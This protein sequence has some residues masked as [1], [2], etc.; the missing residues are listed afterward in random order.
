MTFFL[1]ELK[2]S[3]MSRKITDKILK[4]RDKAE[5]LERQAKFIQQQAD[6][7]HVQADE[8][9]KHAKKLSDQALDFLKKAHG[10]EDI[11]DDFSDRYFNLDEQSDRL[12]QQADDLREKAYKLDDKAQNLKFKAMDLRYE[13]ENLKRERDDEIEKKRREK[14]VAAA[15]NDYMAQESKKFFEN[16]LRQAE[17]GDIFSI[18]NVAECYHTGTGTEKNIAESV[19]WYKL[20]ADAGH[21]AA[22]SQLDE[23][24]WNGE[25]AEQYSPQQYKPPERKHLPIFAFDFKKKS[26]DK[27]KSYDGNFSDVDA[28]LSA[29]Y[30]SEKSGYEE[31]TYRFRESYD[32][33]KRHNKYDDVDDDFDDDGYKGGDGGDGD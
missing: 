28:G 30:N 33:K 8:L 3:V 7:L 18:F 1:Y 11:N 2:G 32:Y 14:Q 21:L 19:K 10:D 4:L 9:D 29:L 27:P 31:S 26:D 20:A 23:M 17:N 5:D 15:A 6:S 25:I 22:Q 16:E 13:I 24:Y 12:V